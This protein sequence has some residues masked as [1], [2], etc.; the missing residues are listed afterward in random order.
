MAVIYEDIKKKNAANYSAIEAIPNRED[1]IESYA[2]ELTRIK[3]ICS[4]NGKL[5]YGSVGCATKLC[6]DPSTVSPSDFLTTVSDKWGF[7]DKVYVYNRN[8]NH[9]FEK[10]DNI[11]NQERIKI[12]NSIA[13]GSGPK[14]YDEELLSSMVCDRESCR[15]RPKAYGVNVWDDPLFL[16][17]ARRAVSRVQRDISVFFKEFFCS[18]PAGWTVPIILLKD[19]NELNTLGDDL[20]KIVGM[21]EAIKIPMSIPKVVEFDSADDLSNIED[22]PYIDPGWRKKLCDLMKTYSESYREYKIREEE[23]EYK[24]RKEEDR[25]REEDPERW[26]EEE[27]RWDEERRRREEYPRRWEE[28]RRREEKW[29][30]TVAESSFG[31]NSG[32][33]NNSNANSG[34]KR[35]YVI[36]DLLGIY[37]PFD[38]SNSKIGQF[39][40]KS[41]SVICLFMDELINFSELVYDIGNMKYV[42]DM[43]KWGTYKDF[44]P[45][46]NT[47]N[48]NQNSNS[49]NTR[50]DNY[51]I[52]YICDE[53]LQNGLTV[54][55]YEKVIAHVLCH[56]LFHAYQ[57]YNI[58]FL[59]ARLKMTE[60]EAEYFSLNYVR[61]EMKD[62][63]LAAL[64]C[65]AT[66]KKSIEYRAALTLF[67]RIFPPS[68]S[69]RFVNAYTHD[70]NAAIKTAYGW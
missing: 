59:N 30:N 54:D 58:G 23:E 66:N 53:D 25:R 1:R 14:F 6:P 31:E 51:F 28:E 56:E 7:D 10:V 12:V 36:G 33:N 26:E 9:D 22:N 5:I 63:I 32:L 13:N 16:F 70:Q 38:W 19:I 24:R 45:V 47:Q 44:Y 3:E 55:A 41:D 18:D 37:I 64:L 2:K 35:V 69:R 11:L 68:N 42:C 15:I 46:S 48:N 60:A 61:K 20:Y 62:F 8:G 39:P 27:R 67:G 4:N 43:I 49:R 17:T 21:K 34:G 57:D 52:D 50:I 40:Q 29:K 65:D